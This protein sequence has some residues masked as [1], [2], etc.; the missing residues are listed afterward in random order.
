M[1]SFWAGHKNLGEGTSF[2]LLEKRETQLEGKHEPPP[3]I[4]FAVDSKANAQREQVLFSG[5]RTSTSKNVSLHCLWHLP[6]SS[7]NEYW[8]QSSFLSHWWAKV[9]LGL[10][11]R[12]LMQNMQSR[13]LDIC[14]CTLKAWWSLGMETAKPSGN[15]VNAFASNLYH[16]TRCS[17]SSFIM[18]WSELLKRISNDELSQMPPGLARLLQSRLLHRIIEHDILWS[19]PFFH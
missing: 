12:I 1:C 4:V 19:P 14:L 18:V 3:T 9:M 7:I 11:C 17:A 5:P 10:S 15:S 8:H 2:Q 16:E 13:M 6:D